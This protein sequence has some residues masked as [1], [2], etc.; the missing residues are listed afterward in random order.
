MAE[1][2]RRAFALKDSE[3]LESYSGST[4]IA[5]GTTYDVARA[6]KTGDGHIVTDD[7]AKV[8]ALALM[9]GPGMPLKEVSLS[10]AGATKKKGGNGNGKKADEKASGSSDGKGN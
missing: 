3:D 1:D 8:E 2:G 10:E 6:L 5:G 7:G 9:T 4:T